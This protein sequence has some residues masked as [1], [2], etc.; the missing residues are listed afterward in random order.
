MPPRRT[1]LLAAAAA[2]LCAAAGGARALTVWEAEALAALNA[3]R[4][5]VSP[6]AHPPLAPLSWDPALA[7]V[8]ADYVSSC[9]GAWGRARGRASEL[10]RPRRPRSAQKG[11]LTT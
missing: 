8:A 6:P 11:S 10:K 1:A 4:A 3:G 9:P 2:A 5:A 7:R